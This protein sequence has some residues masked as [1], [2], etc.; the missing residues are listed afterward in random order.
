MAAL[1]PPPPLLLPLPPQQI[2]LTRVSPFQPTHFPPFLSLRRH[3]HHNRSSYITNAATSSSSGV[4][5]TTTTTASGYAT[6]EEHDAVNIAEDV[7][8]VLFSSLPRA[9]FL[10]PVENYS[11]CLFAC[12]FVFF[13]SFECALWKNWN[14]FSCFRFGRFGFFLFP[15]SKTEMCLGD[16]FQFGGKVYGCLPFVFNLMYLL[17]SASNSKPIGN[18]WRGRP[19]SYISFGGCN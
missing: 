8:Q 12:V 2:P 11:F 1:S 16:F 3:H 10:Y 4:V 7:T 19:G 9:I 15:A 6:S 5:A 14:G 13:V 18:K 17:L